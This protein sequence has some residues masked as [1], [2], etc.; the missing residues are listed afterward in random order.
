MSITK[1]TNFEQIDSRKENKGE[2]LLKDDL[3]IVSKTEI[4]EADFGD[5]KHD[6]MEVSIYDVNN[7]LLPN[8]T[9]NNVA[10]IKPN[11]IKNYMYDIVNAGGQKELAINVEK[12]LNDLGYSN[13]ILKVNLNFVR[14]KIGTDNNLTR[15]WIQEISPSREEVR[16][17]PLKTNNGNI[18]QN[19]NQEFKNIH[20]LSKD[21]KYYKKNILDALDKFEAGSLSVIDDA[22][23][24]KFGNDFRSVLR[25]DF[26]LRDLDTF[27]KRIFENFRDSIK[28]WVNNRYYD[29]SQSTFG[30]PSEI[31]FESCGQYDFNMLL[32]E[33]QSIL[34]NCIQFNTKALQRRQVDIKQLPK[35]FGIVELRKQ[36]QNNLDSFGTKIDIKRNIYMPDKVDVTVTGTSALPPIKTIKEVLITEKEFEP[37]KPP[38]QPTK[39]SPSA[40]NEVAYE[41][42]LLNRHPS[43]NRTIILRQLGTNGVISYIL[44]PG[45]SRTVCA[46]EN[47]VSVAEGGYVN[48]NKRSICGTTPTNSKEIT[49]TTKTKPN[50]VDTEFST[51]AQ[52]EIGLSIID[53]GNRSYSQYKDAGLNGTNNG[54]DTTFL[55]AEN[56]PTGR[57]Y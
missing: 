15:V 49:P 47:S 4:E 41:Y 56:D 8:K 42:E 57:D 6:V 14:N 21:F 34:N 20:N 48:I 54:F 50:L 7:V 40:P 11:D 25:K 12:L 17:V 23:V 5:C 53:K 44:A 26:G 37:T 27:H 30:K 19:T 52:Q 32:G 28:N 36:I 33:I 18:N 31:R 46:I 3:L 39:P 16:I 9:G 22:L 10:Y 45:E 29:V 51:A 38:K 13:G 2:F 55:N 24:A 1:Y 43:D 35:E